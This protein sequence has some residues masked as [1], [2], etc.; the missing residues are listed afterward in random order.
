[1]SEDKLAFAKAAL[2]FIQRAA[3]SQNDLLPIIPPGAKLLAKSAVDPKS[4]GKIPGRYNPRT[5]EW[6][7]L[8]GAWPTMGVSASFSAQAS[9]WPTDNVGLRAENWPGLDIDVASDEARELVETLAGLYLGHGP[10]RVRAGAPRALIVFKKAGDEPIRKMRLVFKDQAGAE[11][12]V[13]LLAHGQQYLIAGVHPSGARYEW[14]EGADLATWGA[15]SLTKITAEDARNFFD[16]LHSDVVARGW[17][18]VRDIRLRPSAGG[19]GFPVKDLEPIVAKETALAALKAIPNTEDVLPMREDLVGLLA[20]FKAAVGKDSDKCTNAVREWAAAFDWADEGYVDGVWHSLTHVRVGPERLFGL[21]HKFGFVGD[22]QEDFK[23]DVDTEKKIAAAQAMADEEDAKLTLVASKLVYW[24]DQM[25][26]I[27]KE[28]GQNLSHGALNSFHGLGT[29]IAPSGA[30]GVRSA[31]NKLINSGKVSQVAGVTYLPG[32]PQLA[33]WVLNGKGALYFNRWIDAELNLPKETTDDRVRPWLDHIAYL[34][35]NQDDREY[36]IDFLAHLV[37]HRGRKIR[38]APII[39]GN[40]GVGKDLFLRPILRGLAHNA[41]TVQPQDL[42]GRFIDFYEKELVIVEEMMRFEKNEVYERM[43][44][45]ISGTASDTNTIE[46]KFQMPY[47]VPNVVNFIF[48][49]NHSDALNLSHDDRRFF[50]INSHATAKE[51]DY[52]TQLADAFYDEQEGWKHVVTWLRQRDISRFNPNHRPKMNEDKESMIRESQ[53]LTTLWLHE[54]LNSGAY[55]HRSILTVSE[56]LFR[57]ASDFSIPEAIRKNLRYPSQVAN[58]LRYARWHQRS[59]QIRING[60]GERPYC[61]T[62]EIAA[63]D[64]EMFRARYKAE[65][66]KKLANVG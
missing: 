9:A 39:I 18:V 43:K 57:C 7:G 52:Y 25:T 40:Q 64:N 65:T 15:G 51:N 21:A 63:L 17:T 42:M 34:F 46:R 30:T 20:A 49:S 26:F 22:A 23:D 35:E 50:V 6:S 12:A 53:P 31:A 48:F 59:R 60:Q 54:E 19:I 36:L 11:H 16:A 13:E 47:E 10:V 44:A 58:A 62:P 41:R 28:T 56:I 4:A 3:F 29:E 37:Q 55:K 24:P 33:T 66:E 2:P 8:T 27:I 45:T 1:M 38:W 32:K 14:R 5:Q 61:K